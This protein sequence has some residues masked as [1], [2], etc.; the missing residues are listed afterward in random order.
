MFWGRKYKNKPLDALPV[1]LAP[2]TLK[3][4]K[5]GDSYSLSWTT[6]KMTVDI[7][8][9]FQVQYK[10]EDVSWEVRAWGGLQS[11]GGREHPGE[12]SSG[13]WG[14]RLCMMSEGSE[15]RWPRKTPKGKGSQTKAKGGQ[16]CGV[17]GLQRRRNFQKHLLGTPSHNHRTDLFSAES[18]PRS[19]IPSSRLPTGL[20]NTP[21]SPDQ[22]PRGSLRDLG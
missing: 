12:S 5:T 19:E 4:T 15:S 1:Q 7:T 13:T 2:P 16:S 14:A 11:R 21:R 20:A 8:C 18:W 10:S 22:K 3:A 6:K 9:T 17:K